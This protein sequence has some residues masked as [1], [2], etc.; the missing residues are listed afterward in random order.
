M[1]CIVSCVSCDPLH[2][3]DN[4][5]VLIH[6]MGVMSSKKIS[7]RCLFHPRPTTHHRHRQPTSQCHICTL[8]LIG[9]KSKE[10]GRRPARLLFCVRHRLHAK[11]RFNNNI[12][13]SRTERRRCPPRRAVKRDPDFIFVLYPYNMLRV[14]AAAALLVASSTNGMSMPTVCGMLSADC[15]SVASFRGVFLREGS[16][17][18]LRYSTENCISIV[19]Y[20]TPFQPKRLHLPVNA[21]RG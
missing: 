19:I 8:T 3:Y 21:T 15:I 13:P 16:F 5:Y 2:T 17:G 4:T 6:K 14:A 12:V 7:S 18:R 20:C 9:T 1:L 10:R 11:G